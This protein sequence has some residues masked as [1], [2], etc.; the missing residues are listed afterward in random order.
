MSYLDTHGLTTLWNKIKT[1]IGN[2][3][4][5]TKVDKITGKGLS[6]NDFTN[7]YKGTVDFCV[8]HINIDGVAQTVVNH[9]VNLDLSA[10]AKK[11]DV[12]VITDARIE[13]ICEL[14][15]E[16]GFT[17]T[18]L[19]PVYGTWTITYADGGT[20]TKSGTN[21][22]GVYSNVVSFQGTPFAGAAYDKAYTY[23]ITNLAGQTETLTESQHV[24]MQ[25]GTITLQSDMTITN[26]WD[27]D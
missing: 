6:T 18:V 7:A 16:S 21:F 13:E 22:A 4:D 25:T 10:Y 11:T 9:E 8:N 20:E 17:L 3:H 24:F 5:S 15:G 27:D 26:T 19:F 2:Y 12:G 1:Y 14:P 23:D